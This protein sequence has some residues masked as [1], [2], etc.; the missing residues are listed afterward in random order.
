MKIKKLNP[1][2]LRII[3]AVYR[4]WESIHCWFDAWKI[5]E[6]MYAEQDIIFEL[7]KRHVTS[8]F[9]NEAIIQLAQKGRKQCQRIG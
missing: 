5:L 3:P 2:K 1:N 8:T 9:I 4:E 6:S 7:G